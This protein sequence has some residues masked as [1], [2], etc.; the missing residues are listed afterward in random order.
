LED[1]KAVRNWNNKWLYEFNL[2][3]LIEYNQSWSCRL[4]RSWRKWFGFSLCAVP[5][6]SSFISILKAGVKLRSYE[7]EL[8]QASRETEEFKLIFKLLNYKLNYCLNSW[9]SW[10]SPGKSE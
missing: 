3:S 10:R 2:P 1:C 4:G 9:S 8:S 5:L 6:Q 7:R